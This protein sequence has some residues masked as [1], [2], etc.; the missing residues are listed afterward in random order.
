VKI[1]KFKY[2]SF[3]KSFVLMMLFVFCTTTLASDCLNCVCT[4]KQEAKKDTKCCSVKKEMK[5]CADKDK[6]CGMP[7][8]K[9]GKDC[10][11][12]TMKKSDVQ[13]PLTTNETKIA[14]TN[15]LKLSEVSVSLSP[16]NF[17]LQTFNTWRPPEK[18]SK[19][20]ITL[21]NIRI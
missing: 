7:E 9:S 8:K 21:S 6:K 15:N 12:C 13:N 1:F 17:L 4:A 11:N 14:K 10:N 19:I 16:D 5:C 3:F 2:R 18:T 20:F